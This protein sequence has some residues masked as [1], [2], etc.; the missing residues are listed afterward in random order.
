MKKLIVGVIFA[1]CLSAFPAF[2][3]LDMGCYNDCC[4]AGYSPAYCQSACSYSEQQ[5]QRIPQ[6]NTRYGDIPGSALMGEQARTLRM[7]QQMM[8]QQMQRR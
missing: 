4:R 6:L 3:A 8:Q 7:Q 2:A 1:C 5:Q